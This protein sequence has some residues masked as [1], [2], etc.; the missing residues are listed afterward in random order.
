VKCLATMT[1]MKLEG[2]IAEG[3]SEETKL[4]KVAELDIDE[5]TSNK[6]KNRSLG[7]VIW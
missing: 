2:E 1:S 6:V 7:C 4:Q 3:K 5:K